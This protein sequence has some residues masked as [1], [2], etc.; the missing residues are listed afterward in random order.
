M[1]DNVK[2]RENNINENLEFNF[3]MLYALH[4]I[5]KNAISCKKPVTP[6]KVQR[7]SNF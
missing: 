3:V 7:N 5:R 6:T 1:E 2:M 4:N